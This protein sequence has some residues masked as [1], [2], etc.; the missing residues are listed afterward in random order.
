[1]KI[2]F[3]EYIIETLTILDSPAFFNL[4][5]DNRLRLEDFFAGTVARTKTQKET[6][7]Y[8]KIIEQ[9]IKDKVYFP[10]II[11]KINDGS[12]IGL[13][14]IK[15]IDWNIPKAHDYAHNHLF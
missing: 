4:I 6:E 9:Q 5:N 2:Q 12:F 8:C 11:K 15:N 3:K 13:I 10:H 1:M 7:A 14:D